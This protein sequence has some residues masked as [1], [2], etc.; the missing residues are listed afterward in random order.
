MAVA[1]TIWN[2]LLEPVST[3]DDISKFKT[4]IKTCLFKE[5]FN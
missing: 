3:H 2:S 1:P 5:H 4:S